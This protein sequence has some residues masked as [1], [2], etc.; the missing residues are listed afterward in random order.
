MK[1]EF[2]DLVLLND[3]LEAVVI[4]GRPSNHKDDINTYE[5]IVRKNKKRITC[6]EDELLPLAKNR[7]HIQ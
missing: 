4:D 1:Y 5:I 2:G 3:M 7:Y 6:S